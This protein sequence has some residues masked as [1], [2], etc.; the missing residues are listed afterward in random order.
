MKKSKTMRQT[1]LCALCCL[2]APIEG[3][4]LLI[5]MISFLMKRNILASDPAV[6]PS[7]YTFVLDLISICV[8][9]FL[10]VQASFIWMG[11]KPP[12]YRSSDWQTASKK[13]WSNVLN[14]ILET[15]CLA[16]LIFLNG[17]ALF[18]VMAI[19]ITCQFILGFSDSV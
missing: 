10:A 7:W 11:K 15:G 13:P 12:L 4:L 5:N 1:V 2:A 9:L 3:S 14:A 16:C 6:H 8:L 19:L 17:I 18:I